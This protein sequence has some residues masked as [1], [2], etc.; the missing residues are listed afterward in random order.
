[1]TAIARRTNQGAGCAAAGALLCAAF[2]WLALAPPAQ[3]APDWVAPGT[4]SGFSGSGV[5]EP[6]IAT[7]ARGDTVAVWVINGVVQARLRP[8]GGPFGPIQTLSDAGA[9]DPHVA[10][11][12]G[13]NFMAV[14]ERG[15]RVDSAYKPVAG[16]AVPRIIAANNAGE[17]DVA[18]NP[19]GTAVV[20]W[21]RQDPVLD[22]C[23]VVRAISR[24]PTGAFSQVQRLSDCDAAGEDARD[25][26]IALNG[27]G[28]GIIAFR[29]FN[30]ATWRIFAT[31]RISGA[32]FRFPASLVSAANAAQ[33]DPAVAI[34]ELG[35]GVAVWERAG[36]IEATM[37]SQ[38][39]GAFPMGGAISGSG[40]TSRPAVAVGPGGTFVAAWCL[41]AQVQSA[42]GS[43]SGGFGSVQPVS[44]GPCNHAFNDPVSGSMV[45]PVDVAISPA[46]HAHVAFQHP[47]GGI[48]HIQVA[49]RTGSSFG[50]SETVSGATDVAF[51][52]HLGFDGQGNAALAFGREPGSVQV[53][54]FD[55]AAPSITAFNGPGVVTAGQDSGGWFASAFD[56]WTGA[57]L[58][59][60]WGDGTASDGPAP[61]HRYATPGTYVVTVVATDGV[62]NASSA[63]R[64]VQVIHPDNDGDGFRADQ[65]CNDANAAIRP[66]AREIKG[67]NVDENCD[68]IKEARPNNPARTTAGWSVLG[69]RL[70]LLQFDLTKA[71]RNTKAQVRCRGKRCPFKKTKTRKMRRGKTNLLKVFKLKGRKTRFRAKQRLEVWIRTPGYNGK[72]SRYPLKAGKIPS[73]RELCLA[74]GT[75]RPVKR[76]KLPQ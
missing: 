5:S 15:G 24:A 53:A 4:V 60:S 45:A 67:N 30:G 51:G 14:W 8:P 19:N 65:D 36:E 17:P 26:V 71:V 63:Q 49:R 43:A 16:A 72:V 56:V 66:G 31:A 7:N 18:M 54:A 62:L 34:D 29:K 59:W 61:I 57:A 38:A 73:S 41:G 40:M 2:L 64:T 76:C 35:R 50:P 69:S 28:D 33:Q 11:D 42:T 44:N 70:T 20:T 39:G 1:V 55:G 74:P 9:T 3:A 58:R 27:R 12:A 52:P 21:F 48:Q 75:R 46:G 68:K 10:I 37:G 32:N 6:D 13:G 47:V 22:T 25:P 23:R